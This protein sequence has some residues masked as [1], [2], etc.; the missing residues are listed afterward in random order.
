MT[1]TLQPHGIIPAMV[2]PITGDDSI[3]VAGL[4]RLSRHLIDGGCHGLFAI[5]SQGEFWAF[6]AQEKEVV[7]RTVVEEVAGELPVYAGSAA[8]TTREAV[9]LTELADRCG[10]DAVSVLTPFFISP[11][12][13]ELFDHY[14]AIAEATSLPV[15]LY[16]NPARTGVQ[17]SVDL[18]ARLAELDNI[19]GIKDSSGNL[20]LTSAYIH[21]TPQDFSV[22]MGNDALILAGLV[23]GTRGAIAATANVVPRLVVDIYDHY[24]AGDLQAAH[25][26]QDRLAALRRAFTWG[27]FPIVIKEA[28]DMIGLPAG[29]ARAPVGPMDEPQRDRLRQL[30]VELGQ[31]ET[32]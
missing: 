10:A 13:Q 11:T 15:L 16:A 30:L 21:A 28:L 5:G 25:R 9:A 18:V 12:D 4:R 27:T 29:P 7:W 20:G 8:V 24:Q 19:V 6:S 26:A 23:Y 22:L 32:T 2:T 14:R 31:L 3:D 1:T 17:L